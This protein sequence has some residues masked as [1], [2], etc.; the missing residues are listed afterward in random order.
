[1]TLYTPQTVEALKIPEKSKFWTGA[2]SGLSYSVWGFF[3]T[4]EHYPNT[5]I[6]FCH[7]PFSLFGWLRLLRSV[8]MIHFETFSFRDKAFLK[9]KKFPESLELR[10]WKHCYFGPSQQC[11][12]SRL[13]FYCHFLVRLLHSCRYAWA[14]WYIHWCYV[15]N[16]H[17]FHDN[18][19]NQSL[20]ELDKTIAI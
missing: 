14:Q 13:F 1:M 10:C 3:W 11:S 2:G 16:F 7:N 6:K 19:A 17:L 5:K 12:T 20:V 15:S 18:S 9:T 8:K 4:I